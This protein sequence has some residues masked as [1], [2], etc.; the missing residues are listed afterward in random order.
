MRREHRSPPRLARWLL[1]LRV[2]EP[3]REFLVG[4]LL[5]EYQ[6]RVRADSSGANRWFWGEVLRLL[7][8]AWPQP[9]LIHDSY[10]EQTMDSLINTFRSAIRA[11]L[12]TPALTALVALTLAIGIGATT[13]VYSVARVALLGDPPYPGADRLVLIW[14]RDK[15]GGESNV[16]FAT[17]E[18]IV[19]E[20]SV[21]SSAAAMSYWQPTLSDDNETERLNGQRVTH[22]FFEVLGVQPFLGRGFVEAEDRRGAN[23][24]VVLGH[25]L[26]Q[27]RFGSD[28][29]IVGRNVMINGVAFLVAG[30][31][32]A[33]FE[34]LLQ[35]GAEIWSP[36]GYAD[37]L[38]W[39]CRTCRHLRM[40]GR[41]RADVSPAA[42]T[43]ALNTLKAEL[44]RQFPTAYSTP[45][46][47]VTSLHEYVVR[48][49]RFALIALLSAV[50]LVA[51]IGCVN[52]AGL[53]LGRAL[54]RESEFAVRIALGASRLRLSAGL[55]SEG[56]VLGIIAATMGTVLAVWG[57]QLVVRL[58]P[59]GVPR[60][61][62]VRIDGGVLV[63]AVGLALVLSLAASL[64]PA[65]ALFG[66]R[67]STQEGIRLGAR[68]L[69]GSGR[70]RLRGALV[71]TEVALSVMLLAGATLLFQSLGKLMAVDAGFAT[72]DRL[73]MELGLSGP[74]YADSGVVAATWRQVLDA[75]KAV[76]GVRNVGLASMIPLGGNVDMY[77]VRLEDRGEANPA[78]D[79]SALRYAV[80]P[81]YVETMG[82]PVVE[83]RALT[84]SDNEA[85]PPVV[86]INE[87]AA[88]RLFPSG[89]AVGKRLR[90]GGGENGPLRTVV[91][92]VGSTKHR[93]LDD[94]AEM[95][96]YL[97][98]TQW[99]EEA[100]LT[101]VVHTSVRSSSVVPSVRAALRGVTRDI[102][103]TNVATLE[104]LVNTSTADRRF[105]L[106]LF[107]CFAAVA[108]ILAA[109]GLFGVLSAAVVERTREIGVRSALGATSER[110][111]GM[112]VRQGMTFAAIGIAAGLVGMWGTAR[113]I[114]TLLY[115]V[116]PT[117]P[118]V[119]G[120]VVLLPGAI[121]LAA[122]ALP[123]WR[124][125]RV[126]PMIALRES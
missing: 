60:L 67:R 126:D 57:V 98:T 15:N 91:G 84:A 52:A 87:A 116:G 80:T 85:A 109:A 42:A 111:L 19:R 59:A 34:S 31:M 102:A 86:L 2:P 103:I 94:A 68:S 104:R 56:F 17:Y 10:G 21:L 30:V 23:R 61:G 117:D 43:S 115:E 112:V 113:V 5:E 66:G 62:M 53:L 14:E 58:A 6:R 72:R 114:R 95:Q 119:L 82:I 26:W 36:L 18:D 71:A 8:R 51:L 74:R 118:V 33:S 90:M 93:S 78:D 106:V 47:V 75:V 4:D 54:R 1:E 41:L 55:A 125:A 45:G 13:S 25:G 81:D 22:R 63:V 7:P 50:G 99:G 29:S 124:A 48:G 120:F 83:G 11:L 46:M 110:I 73:T 40:V 49:T 44:V 3:D 77:S 35:P 92:V 32:P 24:V 100:G 79:P 123:A 70:H 76:P 121:A 64:L 96:V 12:R 108:L 97:P 65:F 39:A 69:I 89:Q 20:N 27:R 122:S 88:A 38:P 9:P 37:S 16:G 28:S 105:A 107:S 101:L